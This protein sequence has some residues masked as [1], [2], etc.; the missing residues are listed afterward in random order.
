MSKSDIAIKGVACL[1]IGFIIGGLTNAAAMHRFISVV[2]C[3]I[4][5]V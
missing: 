1:V 5:L 3:G 2:F 4:A